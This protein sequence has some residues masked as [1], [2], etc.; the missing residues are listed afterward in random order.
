M[1]DEPPSTESASPLSLRR[2]F[3][4]IPRNRQELRQLLRDIRQHRLIDS[5]ALGIIEGA[6]TVS[7]LQVREVMVP[8]PQMVVI[9]RDDPPDT[10][11][12]QIIESGHSRFPV[13]GDEEDEVLG[14]LL[15]KDLLAR[16]L[17]NDA[18]TSLAALIRPATFVPESKRLNVLLR[19][20]RENRNHMAIV[21]NEYGNVSGLITI[22]DVLEEIVGE[23][24]DEYDDGSELDYV[25]RLSAR[26]Y[27]VK[28]LMPIETFNETFQAQLP[29][30]EF[31]TLGGLVLNA[32]GRLPRRNET[33]ELQGFQFR[34][35][36]TDR[37]RIHLLRLTVP[38]VAAST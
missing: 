5:D 26:D 17:H 23:I 33:L 16:L 14:I 12:Q 10:Y 7:E 24:D 6:L 37:R 35:L 27:M 20:F 4:T 25:H 34:V 21:I 29:D 31:D 38:D 9:R 11:L 8:R 22:E 2:L 32:F 1:N 3:R 36:S 13:F 15:A 30:D 19:E 28:A 18:D